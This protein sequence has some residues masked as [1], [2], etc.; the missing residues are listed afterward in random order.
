MSET[1]KEKLQRVNK[2]LDRKKKLKDS[3]KSK[4][5]KTKEFFLGD[6]DER[7]SR[8]D[9]RFANITRLKQSGRMKKLYE[10]GMDG[11]Q[12]DMDEFIR[13]QNK[14]FNTKGTMSV[15][16]RGGGVAIQGTKFKGLK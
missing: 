13:L 14:Y 7:L 15:F 9:R 1:R 11:N 5:T 6:P 10:S 2:E 4:F 8:M 12:Q 16:S 3:K